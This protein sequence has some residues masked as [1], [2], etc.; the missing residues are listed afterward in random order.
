MKENTFVVYK[1]EYPYTDNCI[2][3]TKY[4]RHAGI[5]DCMMKNYGALD[6]VS[7]VSYKDNRYINSTYLK[8]TDI[9]D[10]ETFDNPMCKEVSIFTYIEKDDKESEDTFDDYIFILEDWGSLPQF[11]IQS[12]PRIDNIDYVT[13][14]FGTL[15]SWFGFSFLML[16]PI[17]WIFVSR[18][19]SIQSNHDE[20]I[21]KNAENEM[22]RMKY[23]INQLVS[24]INQMKLDTNKQISDLR[25]QVSNVQRHE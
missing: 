6:T 15:G 1:L 7:T 8:R 14:I 12:K 24:V 9:C 17:P 21:K 11:S 18:K 23:K 10:W 16:N 3:Y 22:N 19:H 2:H 25:R 13:Y 4:S 20:S 5:R